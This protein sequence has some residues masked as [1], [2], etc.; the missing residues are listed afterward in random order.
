MAGEAPEL[1]PR[2]GLLSRWLAE[3]P[4]TKLAGCMLLLAGL[5]AAFFYVVDLSLF[6]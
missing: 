2:Q 4:D 6:N 1:R 5:I 3:W